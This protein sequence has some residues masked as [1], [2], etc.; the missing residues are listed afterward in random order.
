MFRKKNLSIPVFIICI[1]F[2]FFYNTTLFSQTKNEKSEKLK[3]QRTENLFNAVLHGD[4]KKTKEIIKREPGLIH[5]KDVGKSGLLRHAVLKRNI[6]MVA[7]LIKMGLDPND[8][9]RGMTALETAVAINDF[10]IVKLLINQFRA[11]VNRKGKWE[12]TPIL[13]AAE[14]GN[15]LI[16]DF[17]L[18]KG[19]RYPVIK[20]EINLQMGD[21][22]SAGL[23]NILD[24]IVQSGHK[25]N[26]KFKN[27]FNNSFLHLAAKGGLIKWLKLLLDKGLNID[28]KNNDGWA[29]LHFAVLSGD[30]KTIDYLIKRKCNKNIL[31]LRGENPFNIAEKFHKNE[32]LK[33]L[34]VRDFNIAKMQ[35]PKLTSKYI[36][37]ELPVTNPKPFS[38]GIVSLESTREHGPLS[39]SADFKTLC[40]IDTQRHKKGI[41]RCFIMNKKDGVWSK[42]EVVLNEITSPVIS[43]DGHR[44]Y[45]LAKRKFPDG[46]SAKD[47]DIYYVNRMSQNK[48]SDWINL[49][50]AVNSKNNESSVSVTKN[51]TVYFEYNNQIYRSI[52][53]DGKYQAK[54]KIPP[55]LD[56]NRPQKAPFIAADESYLIFWSNTGRFDLYISFRNSDDSW[57]SAENLGKKIGLKSLF[58]YPT[59]TPDNKYLIYNV[60]NRGYFWQAIDI[61]SKLKKK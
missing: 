34:K 13:T 52:M 51:N 54:E 6:Q 31:T 36:D 45:F 4:L 24:V 17:L 23:S 10:N 41:N 11:D 57:T 28:Q 37:S 60:Y 48:W 50:Y 38:N 12:I 59:I 49:G 44:I 30:I 19:A 1:M 33:K 35:F 47:D 21:A 55:I 53:K 18:K 46:K 39:F 16:V 27:K 14:T 32:L 25:I 56:K 43:P 61:F 7:L 20:E 58:L 5:I 2:A 3:K 15:K 8:D 26:Y 42:P 29:P 9:D 22:L 40:W